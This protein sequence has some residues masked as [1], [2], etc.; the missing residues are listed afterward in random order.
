[1]W[2]SARIFSAISCG[3]SPGYFSDKPRAAWRAISGVS[4]RASQGGA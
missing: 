2:K 3:P 4:S 1:L